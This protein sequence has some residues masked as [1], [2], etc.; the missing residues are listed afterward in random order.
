MITSRST[1]SAVEP[2]YDFE[3]EGDGI[4]TGEGRFSPGGLP[5]H[6]ARIQRWW[7]WPPIP[8]RKPRRSCGSCSPVDPVISL[9]RFRPAF[10]F[11]R[12]IES[13]L[14]RGGGGKMTHLS[15]KVRRNQ[16]LH[17][18]KKAHLSLVSVFFVMF[19]SD[20]CHSFCLFFRWRKGAFR[21]GVDQGAE[22]RQSTGRSRRGLSGEFDASRS[23]ES[24][25]G[26]FHR[27]FRFGPAPSAPGPSPKARAECGR[28]SSNAPVAPGVSAGPPL[29]MTP[30]HRGSGFW[31]TPFPGRR[32]PRVWAISGDGGRWVPRRHSGPLR[33]RRSA[34]LDRSAAVDRPGTGL[35]T[36]RLGGNPATRMMRCQAVHPLPHPEDL[37]E[38]AAVPDGRVGAF[39]LV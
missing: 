24:P 7:P 35:L 8:V 2:V 13:D 30:F 20:R 10:A 25:V 3:G 21:G 18:R 31:V 23:G 11:P 26:G 6:K 16:S 39:A 15:K 34:R 1:K 14:S 17:C 9:R 12:Q 38:A 37:T 19:S 28:E 4:W 22:R 5:A 29:A 32:D 33:K 36:R 27:R